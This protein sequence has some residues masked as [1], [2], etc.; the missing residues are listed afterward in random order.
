VLIGIDFQPLH[1][2]ASGGVVQWLNGIFLAYAGS[3]ADDQLAVFVPDDFPPIFAGLPSIRLVTGPRARL[4]ELEVDFLRANGG[5]ILIR[6]YPHFD[7][8][9]FPIE[10]QITFIPD[11]QHDERPEFFAPDVLRFRR[12][13]FGHLLAKS[14]AIATMTEFSRRTILRNAWTASNDVFLAP[15]SVLNA[16]QPSD[17]SSPPWLSELDRFKKFFFF[18]ANAWPHK[19]HERLFEAFARALPRLPGGTGLVLTG[20]SPV[21]LKAFADLPVLHL[22]YVLQSHLRLLY[23]RSSALAFFSMYEGFGMPL[24]EAFHHGT[25]VICSNIPALTEVGGDAVLACS[26]TDAD[27]MAA[28]MV[29]IAGDAELARELVTKGKTRLTRYDWR[30]SARA[31]R[32]A[33]RRVSDRAGGKRPYVLRAVGPTIT[34]IV[35]ATGPSRTLPQCIDAIRAQEYRRFTVGIV[36][37]PAL[38]K[39]TKLES[40]ARIHFESSGG[41]AEMALAAAIGSLAGDINLAI[42]PDC[43]FEQGALSRIIDHFAAHPECDILACATVTI[44]PSGAR[45]TWKMPLPPAEDLRDPFQLPSFRFAPD[46]LN[47]LSRDPRYPRPL[48]AWRKRIG[49]L[50]APTIEAGLALDFDHPFHLVEAG[51]AVEVLAAPVATIVASS[52]SDEAR[53][54]VPVMHEVQAILA[55]RGREPRPGFIRKLQSRE[56]GREPSG[57]I[58]RS[59][60]RTLSFRLVRRLWRRRRPQ[61]N[62]PPGSIPEMPAHGLGFRAGDEGVSALK[63][64]WSQPESWGTWSI[65]SLALMR[66]T[67]RRTKSQP[68]TLEMAYRAFVS[69][70]H[71]R[72]TIACQIGRQIIDRWDYAHAEPA[73]VHTLR[74][75]SKCIKPD[76]EIALEFWLSNPTSPRALGANSDERLLGI[77]VEWIRQ[78]V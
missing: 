76:G 41:A 42:R 72:L 15:P 27:A 71:P 32:E 20:S 63:R 70:R 55:K 19:N 12:L 49:A 11:M 37:A 74:V 35:N 34:V 2:G 31:V 57:A 77:G 62:P 78:V 4:H 69:P 68:V 53:H 73:T 36:G 40:D 56:A 1:Y 23:E 8:P 26:P 29:R 39:T 10:R 50:A 64:G 44:A 61:P 7:H 30:E 24:L 22:G 58:P 43:H 16:K 47:Q 75:P 46:Y 9:D 28:L 54:W 38:A 45:S 66:L 60:A 21:D 33:T 65:G 13:G 48:V 3:F 5:E 6:S 67:V 17:T 14:G 25:P 59:D 52:D 18:P 51:G